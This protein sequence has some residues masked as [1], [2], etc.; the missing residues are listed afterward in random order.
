MNSFK[1]E[2]KKEQRTHLWGKFA[3]LYGFLVYLA[4]SVAQVIKNPASAE[5]A[6]DAGLI[7]GSGRCPE[8]GNGNLLQFS[9]LENF[10]HRGAW[11]ATLKRVTKSQTRLSS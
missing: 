10:K 2:G 1:M 11:G 8:V 4:S 9:C 5:D 6:R 7:P 3:P